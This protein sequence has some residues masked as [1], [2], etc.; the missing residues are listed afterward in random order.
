MPM[1]GKG[2]DI[3][4]TLVLLAV[5]VALVLVFAVLLTIQLVKKH[6]NKKV[7]GPKEEFD[8][9][10]WVNALGGKD[11]IINLEAKGSRLIVYLT[12]NE[13]I[14]KDELHNLGVTSV[15][16]SQ[17]KITIVLREKAENIQNLLQ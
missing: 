10:R 12:N 5:L 2:N 11:N 1:F 4:W 3:S 14:N 15:I 6:K 7:E 16:S 17:D 13:L 8:N 9:N